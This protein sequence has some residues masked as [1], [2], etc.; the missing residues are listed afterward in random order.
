MYS[1]VYWWT[2]PLYYVGDES[3]CHLGGFGCILSLLSY[4]LGK[5]LLANTADTDQTPHYVASDL[6]LHCLPI[7]DFPERMG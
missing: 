2:V 4:F 6:G 1:I 7:T 5:I 3:I